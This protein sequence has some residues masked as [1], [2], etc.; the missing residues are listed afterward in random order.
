MLYVG[1][2]DKESTVTVLTVEQ[3]FTKFVV[4]KVYTPGGIIPLSKVVVLLLVAIGT[5]P[6]NG[7]IGLYQLC[8]TL[9]VG[10]I[11]VPVNVIGEE[12]Q[13]MDCDA[14]ATVV[15]GGTVFVPIV[16]TVVAVHPVVGSIAVTVIVFAANIV[17]E[18]VLALKL[19]L[20]HE[21]ESG[22]YV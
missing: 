3:P 9:D 11:A 1:N 20:V 12:I 18:V 22:P 8:C 7:L 21:Y 10:L 13:L 19:I 2:A 17:T 5:P 16:T 6:G 15:V 14:G 4:T